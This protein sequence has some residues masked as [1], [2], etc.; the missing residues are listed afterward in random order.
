MPISTFPFVF[1]SQPTSGNEPA[2][3][4]LQAL[5]KEDRRKMGLAMRK[6]QIGWPLGM[7]LCRPMG[8]GLHD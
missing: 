7:P 5:G 8:D 2:L 6:V 4:W 3:E 1:W